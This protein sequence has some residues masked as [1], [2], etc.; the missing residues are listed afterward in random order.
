M[1]TWWWQIYRDPPVPLT[2]TQESAARHAARRAAREARRSLRTARGQYRRY[3]GAAGGS[4]LDWP[5]WHAEYLNE[6]RGRRQ[7]WGNAEVGF[8]VPG[9]AAY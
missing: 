6:Y 9:S 7:I 5:R 3:R 1:F 8:D 2:P 4:Y